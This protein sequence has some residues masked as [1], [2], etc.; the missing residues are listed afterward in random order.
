MTKKRLLANPIR[1]Q[2]RP[3]KLA[4]R[5]VHARSRCRRRA[6]RPRRSP[7][8][9]PPCA[10]CLC[11]PWRRSPAASARPYP[12]L[13]R[14]RRHGGRPGAACHG[15]SRRTVTDRE[16]ERGGGSG[17]GREVVEQRAGSEDASG[18]ATAKRVECALNYLVKGFHTGSVTSMSSCARKPLLITCSKEDKSI[19]LWNYRKHVCVDALTFENDAQ[20][21]FCFW[22]ALT[23]LIACDIF[24]CCYAA[25]VSS[26]ASFLSLIFFLLPS[27]FFS[28]NLLFF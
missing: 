9:T 28:F 2:G 7:P 8:R 22:I 25:C 4:H 26:L 19:R 18:G 1:L 16:E 14:R 13:A 6:H 10:A 27:F 12:L 21:E 17:S 3:N 23:V 15:R 24:L 11:G 5:P 20:R